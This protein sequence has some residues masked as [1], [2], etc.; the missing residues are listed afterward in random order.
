[1]NAVVLV[2]VPAQ[3]GRWQGWWVACGQ[4]A[5]SHIPASGLPAV[6]VPASLGPGAPDGSMNRQLVFHGEV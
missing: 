2:T 1:M 4:R 3:P 5:E 6:G